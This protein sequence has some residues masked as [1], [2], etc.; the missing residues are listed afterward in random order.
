MV[1]INVLDIYELNIYQISNLMFKVKIN[2]AP[3]T[4]KNQFSEI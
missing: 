2:V 4:F 1:R 3:C